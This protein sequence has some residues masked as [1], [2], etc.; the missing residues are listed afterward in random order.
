MKNQRS[1]NIVLYAVG[2]PYPDRELW[3]LM[4]KPMTKPKR[5]PEWS[6]AAPDTE[7]PERNN[8]NMRTWEEIDSEREERFRRWLGPDLHGWLSDLEEEG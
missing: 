1:H 8:D 2:S 3:R 4:M 7:M 5:H 6:I